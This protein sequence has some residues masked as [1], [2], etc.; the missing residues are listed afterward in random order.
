MEDAREIF[1][2]VLI[3]L[4]NPVIVVA[5]GIALI[6]LSIIFQICFTGFKT[7]NLGDQIMVWN[8]SEFS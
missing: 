7:D 3:I 2:Y 8:Y 6:T 4:H 5:A 1:N